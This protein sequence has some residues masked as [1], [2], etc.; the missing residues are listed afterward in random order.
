M[1][2]FLHHSF[3]NLL[4]LAGTSFLLARPFPAEPPP[5]QRVPGRNADVPHLRLVA[6]NSFFRSP[7]AIPL[8]LG[9]VGGRSSRCKLSFPRNAFCLLYTPVIMQRVVKRGC[10]HPCRQ[11][12]PQ[13]S[14]YIS[15]IHRCCDLII[16]PHTIC[17][18]IPRLRGL[19]L[20]LEFG[21]ELLQGRTAPRCCISAYCSALRLKVKPSG[22]IILQPAKRPI[23]RCLHCGG[24]VRVCQIPYQPSGT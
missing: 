10:I 3:H 11:I 8:G 24:R 18:V 21:T 1:S 9:H 23:C 6:I 19:H 2:C 7:S 17:A 13:A 15:I 5:R 16:V 4:P 14:N 22:R 12:P 20:R